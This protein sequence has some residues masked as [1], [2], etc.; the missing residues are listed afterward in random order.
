[1]IGTLPAADRAARPL[2]I[3][4]AMIIILT[5]AHLIASVLNPILLALLVA[6]A[7]SPVQDLLQRRGM[8]AGAAHGLTILSVLLTLLTV[9]GILTA[10]V[11]SLAADLPKYQVALTE[12][13]NGLRATLAQ[14]GMVIPDNAMLDAL[15]PAQ[16]ADVARRIVGGVGNLLG[17]GVL[18]L[19]LVAFFLPEMAVP[20]PGSAA[21]PRLAR[22][23]AYYADIRGYLS[24]TALLGLLNGTVIAVGLA[25]LGVPHPLMWGFLYALMSFIPGI[26]MVIALVPALLIGFVERGGGVAAGVVLLYVGS[27]FVFDNVVRPRMMKGSLDISP[28]ELIISLIFWSFI[29][30]LVGALL[31][32]PLTMSVKR[33][34]AGLSEAP[35]AAA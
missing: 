2:L 32:V 19:L 16:I 29:F 13:L 5:G 26:G 15:S 7:V 27:N 34:L 14:R 17:Q 3:L 28:A 30:G 10:S 20:A 1:M 11:A 18:V 12:S 9:G 24:V 25:L 33:L 21:T 8:G 23:Q 6:V 22:F 35:A 31:A 4:S